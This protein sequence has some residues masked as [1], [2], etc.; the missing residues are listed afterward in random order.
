MWDVNCSC[1]MSSQMPHI[2]GL[3]WLQ[4]G[5]KPWM[6]LTESEKH[7]LIQDCYTTALSS[8]VLYTSNPNFFIS[9]LQ[10]RIP[11]ISSIKLVQIE[12]EMI[13]GDRMTKNSSQ[14]WASSSSSMFNDEVRIFECWCPRR[15]AVRKVNTLKNPERPFYTCPL[16]NVC[17]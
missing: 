13:G 10:L 15:C 7:F 12:S 3:I 2:Q 17:L 5:K 8:P 11:K 9:R 4:M 16:P 6:N 14:S 1:N